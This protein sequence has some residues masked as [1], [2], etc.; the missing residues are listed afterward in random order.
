MFA[1]DIREFCPKAW[2]HITSLQ[3][4]SAF[5]N[6]PFIFISFLYIK[7]PSSPGVSFILIKR[8]KKVFWWQ[9][10]TNVLNFLFAL[11]CGFFF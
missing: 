2:C 6:S 5:R 4:T 11:Y 7:T 3:I 1:A 10:E 9:E 8:K